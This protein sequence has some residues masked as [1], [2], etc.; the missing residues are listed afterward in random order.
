M[1]TAATESDFS[2]FTN[3]TAL[4]RE[5]RSNGD[6]PFIVDHLTVLLEGFSKYFILPD[7]KSFDWLRDPINSPPPESFN[8]EE[9]KNNYWPLLLI[10]VAD[11]GTKRR[12]LTDFGLVSR[13]IIH[14]S[15]I[16]PS[17]CFCPFQHHICARQGFLQLLSPNLSTE[18][19][20]ISA[21]NFGQ[22]FHSKLLD[23]NW[24]VLASK[25]IKVT[26]FVV[27]WV[28]YFCSTQFSTPVIN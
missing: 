5:S 2:P 15:E 26:N 23:S 27:H 7:P 3:L 17:D 9:K 12:H 8:F 16:K 6:F 28:S 14:W 1:K 10:R 21:V 4:L 13:R 24:Y 11:W 20:L 19:N 22:Q 18:T 25:L